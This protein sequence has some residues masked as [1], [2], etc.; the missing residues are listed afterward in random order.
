MII[1]WKKVRI[2]IKPGPTDMRKQING[3]SQLVQAELPSHLFSGSLFLFCS[4]NKT[5]LKILYWD[6]TGFSLWLKRL[7]EAKFP[8]PSNTAEAREINM[9]QFKMLLKGIDFFHSHQELFY[10]QV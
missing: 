6:R 1:D 10:K 7:E 9:Q 2:Y 3:L 4:R 5:R 8:W